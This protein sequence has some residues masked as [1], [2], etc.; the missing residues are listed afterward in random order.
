[1]ITYS[2]V[3]IAFSPAFSQTKA[4]KIDMVIP[5]TLNVCPMHSDVVNTE[6]GKCPKCAM[7]LVEK[8]QDN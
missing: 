6:P 3:L 7:A 2:I 5:T 4:D 8:K 1:M